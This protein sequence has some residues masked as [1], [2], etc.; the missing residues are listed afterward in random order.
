L[1]C[2]SPPALFYETPTLFLSHFLSFAIFFLAMPKDSDH[3]ILLLLVF[4]IVFLAFHPRKQC[5]PVYV[6]LLELLAGIHCM[7]I[8]VVAKFMRNFPSRFWWI[9]LHQYIH[10]YTTNNQTSMLK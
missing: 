10:H 8:L 4:F 2:L 9:K 1:D 7:P 3:S 5:N 6:D